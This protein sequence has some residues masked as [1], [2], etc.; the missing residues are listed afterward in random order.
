MTEVLYQLY[1]EPI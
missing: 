1:Y